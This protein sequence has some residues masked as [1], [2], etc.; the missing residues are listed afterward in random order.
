MTAIPQTQ[1]KPQAYRLSHFLGTV[2]S[3]L[4]RTYPAAYWVIA[5]VSEINQKSYGGH[6]YLSLIE[7][8][9]NKTLASARATI[10]KGNIDRTLNKFQ[11]ITGD[12]I[13]P[14][15][16]L[17]LLV[18]VSFHPQYGFSLNIEDINV[19]YTLG[20]YELRK[21]QTIEQLTREGF[22][23][24][25]KSLTLP[26]LLLRLAVITSD[27]AAG[28]GDFKKQ[29]RQNPLGNYIHLHLY[30]A[31]MQGELTT[32]SVVK[33]LNQIIE[34]GYPYDAVLLLRGGGSRQ[35]LSAFD[36]YELCAT[37]AQCPLPVLTGI[38]HERDES[39]ADLVAY[40]QLKTPTALAEF[41]LQR[42][43]AQL[44]LLQ[45]LTN[46]L[47]GLLL[48]FSLTFPQVGQNLTHRLAHTLNTFKEAEINRIHTLQADLKLVTQKA[49]TQY[50]HQ[51]QYATNNLHNCLHSY[52]TAQRTQ[53][54][55]HSNTVKS[56][57][58]VLLS[59]ANSVKDHMQYSTKWLQTLLSDTCTN[60][61]QQLYN[62]T[63]RLTTLLN[64]TIQQ[65]TDLLGQQERLARS[66]DPRRIMRRG[67]VPVLQE[68]TPITQLN[69]ANVNKPVTILLLD[70][71]ITANIQE[72]HHE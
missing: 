53:L 50:R 24:L 47:T 40:A 18:R 33:A 27:Q 5:E 52:I 69:Q 10:W 44:L 11:K 28:W 41:I 48:Q 22:M 66:L 9:N 16:E 32:P 46:R 68:G 70:G 56:H 72:T 42:L 38:G 23:C 13:A 3:T 64:K 12:R 71:E 8:D 7:A 31:T 29:I 1:D 36:D 37:L 20:Q 4:Q 65:H 60:T 54:Q 14:G 39:V 67:F 25:N 17:M 34:S 6:C 58:R 30:S 62:N 49:I 63:Q 51:L 59:M 15:M 61:H 45:N 43:Q 57:L 35:D 26:T 21:K 19:E 55:S 2:Q